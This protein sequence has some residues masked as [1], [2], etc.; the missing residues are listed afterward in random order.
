MLNFK[1][2][3]ALLTGIAQR[4]S[5]LLMVILA[6]ALVGATLAAALGMQPWL[7]IPARFG[8]LNVPDLGM[9]MQIFLTAL[10]ISLLFFLPGHGRMMQLENSH[11]RFHMTMQDVA[12]AYRLAHEGDREKLFK[13]GAEFDAVRERIAHLRNHPDLA[14]LEPDILEVAAQMSY[15]SRDLARIYS[16]DRVERARTFLRQRHEELEEFR[17]NLKLARLSVDELKHWLMQVEADERVVSK[18]VDAL[19]ADLNAL[20][21]KLGFEVLATPNMERTVVPMSSKPRRDRNRGP[22]GPRVDNTARK[23]QDLNDN[24]EL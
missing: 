5:L 17:S 1:R 4:I 9:Y 12:R 23:E 11:R 16:K 6:L 21:P 24:K 10:C 22:A 8:D 3:M 15:E 2:I 14:G 7:T 13:T 20:L 18:Q 19:G